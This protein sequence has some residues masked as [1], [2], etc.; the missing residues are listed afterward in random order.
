MVTVAA[1]P[2]IEP[3][4]ALVTVKLVKVPTEVK[5]E[6]TIVEFK[7]V[8]VKV[9]A[10]A[11]TVMSVLPSK[12]TVLIFLAVANFVAVPAFPVIVV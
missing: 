5:L 1:F 8:P 6:P 11:V 2:V 9:P 10:A 3:A 4:M 12:S 7:E